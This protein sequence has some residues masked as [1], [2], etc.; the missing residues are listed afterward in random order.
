M[1]FS[2]LSFWQKILPPSILSLIT[3]IFY[4][5]SL[6]YQFMFDDLPYIV[7]NIYIR[8]IAFPEVVFAH[9]RWLPL[10]TNQITYKFFGTNP[11]GY[12]I[13]NLFIHITSGI[14]IF[15][16]LNKILNLLNKKNF[17]RKNSFL[18]S[19]ITTGL[20][21]LHPVQTQTVT[22]ISQM[23]LEGLVNLFSFATIL[24]FVHAT[25]SKNIFSKI[26]LYSF[27]IFLIAIGAGTKEIIIVLPVLIGLIDWFFISKGKISNFKKQIPI[28]ILLFATMFIS[29]SAIKFPPLTKTVALANHS[30]HNNRGNSLTKEPKQIITPTNFF[31]SQFRVILHYIAIYFWPFNLGFDYNFNIPN[32]FNDPTVI[33]SLFLLML[34][35]FPALY[36]FIKKP[37]NPYSFSV[38]WFFAAVL[39]RASFIPSTELVC[40]YKTHLASF[41]IL[42]LISI[43]ILNFTKIINHTIKLFSKQ[44]LSKKSEE[45]FNVF[46]YAFLTILIIGMGYTTRTRNVIW[47]SDLKFWEDAVKKAPQK[48]RGHNN[49]GAALMRA[50]RT[51]DA[52]ES[53]YNAVKCDPS[54]GE[55]HINLAIHFQKK[56]ERKRAYYHFMEAIKSGEGHPELFNNLGMFYLDDKDYTRAKHCLEKAIK[57]FSFYGKG[58]YSRAYLNMGR[59]YHLQNKFDLALKNYE[60]SLQGEYKTFYSYYLHGLTAFELKKFDQATWSLESVKKL[61]PGFQNTETML[62]T[63][64]YQTHNYKQAANNFGFIYNKNQNNLST[65][66]NYAQSLM[67]SGQYEKSIPLFEKCANNKK[68]FPFASLHIAKCLGK[69]NQKEKAFNKIEAFIKGST[70]IAH[71]QMGIDLAKEIRKS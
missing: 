6:T 46:D 52:V 50:G 58:I 8:T 66:Y 44:K 65:G 39:P 48:A 57:L 68:A 40:D 13:G 49:Y 31:Y 24:S 71:K 19:I 55:P 38:A 45:T 67:N 41:G 3:F 18:L 7:Q 21:L 36:F 35:I 10:L 20:Y 64:Y 11:F 28:H 17:L 56:K 27:S 30:I 33:W 22:Y 43:I 5:P 4:Y 70:N 29:L 25:T 42:F 63:I 23:R 53:Y 1:E 2:K 15:F 16:L 9:T 12:R 62:A 51:D 32:G 69:L 61:K 26:S 54:Y 37:S 60:K 34:I 14:L 59:M 47:G